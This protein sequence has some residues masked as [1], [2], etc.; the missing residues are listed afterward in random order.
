MEDR[1]MAG[2]DTE[3]AEGTASLMRGA[4][5][6]FREMDK[7]LEEQRERQA[8][9]EDVQRSKAKVTEWLRKLT[10]ASSESLALEGGHGDSNA[11][12]A[13]SAPSDPGVYAPDALVKSFFPDDSDDGSIPDR[14]ESDG[15]EVEPPSSGPGEAPNPAPLRQYVRPLP[16]LP[17]DSGGG[18][19]AEPETA[20][21]PSD[22]NTTS[23][24]S[25]DPGEAPNPTPPRQYVRPLP[26]LPIDSGG[27]PA[28]DPETAWYS[29]D[30]NTT[31]SPSSGPGE[32]PNPAPPRQYV[33]PLPPLPIAPGP[34]VEAALPVT[35]P[36]QGRSRAP[37]RP[38]G[39]PSA[40]SMTVEEPLRDAATRAQP[41]PQAQVL[42]EP[43]VTFEDLER[44][45]SEKDS[46]EERLKE[47][48]K[49][50]L[51]WDPT[52]QNSLDLNR[53]PKF[54]KEDWQKARGSGRQLGLIGGTHL[55]DSLDKLTSLE[56]TIAWSKIKLDGG[57][58]FK[59]PNNQ[60]WE[61]QYDAAR[62]EVDKIESA[63]N[64]AMIV[65]EISENIISKKL[66]PN[67]GTLRFCRTISEE[68]KK[69]MSDYDYQFFKF[70]L[71]NLYM[72][73]FEGI[74]ATFDESPSIVN[75]AKNCFDILAGPSITNDESW[76][77]NSIDT[78]VRRITQI[79]KNQKGIFDVGWPP[80]LDLQ[81]CYSIEERLSP[82]R[83]NSDPK[84]IAFGKSDYENEDIKR[85][86]LA[87]LERHRKI[88]RDIL[89]EIKDN[90]AFVK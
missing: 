61:G 45:Q 59:R 30:D 86:N 89:A 63:Y 50:A 16:P 78:K 47:K 36:V 70:N 82:Y 76:R 38:K 8:E 6:Q 64:Q 88:L 34:S 62:A 31:S 1:E 81:W 68:M 29:S 67:A 25:S 77:N 39:N 26:P 5:A 56:G 85:D 28:A 73:R 55:G 46:A 2:P 51:A 58:R 10:G 37:D 3:D 21:Y 44:W 66:K 43:T 13:G 53:H 90:P 84:T 32:A 48:L 54:T 7:R 75:M 83:E 69:R 40:P 20:W 12:T 23:S 71:N 9:F 52:M 18:P 72:R 42:P 79:L 4:E 57:N 17:I 49:T 14:S 65:S 11:A 27:G 19:A 22:D 41:L 74:K 35:G 60:E 15:D 87:N 24:P 33:R 80:K